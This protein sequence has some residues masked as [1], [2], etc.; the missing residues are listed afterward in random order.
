MRLGKEIKRDTQ[1]IIISVL[2]L[3]L[4]TLNVSYSAFFSVQSQSTVQEI[5]TGTL[6]VVIDGSQAMNVDELMPTFITELPTSANSTANG[7][8]AVLN[9]DNQGDIA[10]D[11]SVT[12]G[13]DTLPSGSTTKDLISF[14][15]LNIGIFD[16]TNNVWLE[17]GE[18]SN[19]FYTPVTG[20]TATSNNVYPIIR[21]EVAAS[22]QR[23]FR[24][25]VWLSENTPISEIGKLIYLKLDVKSTPINGQIES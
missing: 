19:A 21:D 25:Y 2:V 13:Y 9:L 17:F 6:K 3:T 15:Y 24:V 18:G 1:L 7:N 10:A 5:S 20:L 8:Y 16:V 12:L 22:S 4:I 23:Q 11:F 14:N